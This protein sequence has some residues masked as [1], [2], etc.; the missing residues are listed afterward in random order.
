MHLFIKTVETKTGE[1]N[2]EQQEERAVGFK[3]S[4]TK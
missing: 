2:N 3:R 4:F 1:M